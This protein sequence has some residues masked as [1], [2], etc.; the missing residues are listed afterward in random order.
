MKLKLFYFIDCL[1]ICSGG[2][3]RVLKY[4]GTFLVPLPLPSVLGTEYRYC[5]TLFNSRVIE[6]FFA[7]IAICF[8]FSYR[9]Q[10]QKS[11]LI[12]SSIITN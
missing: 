9:L 4:S 3:Y 11:F 2:Q 1:Y 10:L 5:G 6:S 7:S 12:Y 8:C